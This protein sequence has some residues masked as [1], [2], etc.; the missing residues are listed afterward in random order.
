MG[1]RTPRSDRRSFG[2]NS[3]RHYGAL[4][5][6]EE[7]AAP[8]PIGQTRIRSSA[9]I[10]ELRAAHAAGASPQQ[11]QALLRQLETLATELGPDHK[12]DWSVRFEPQRRA[13]CL[14]W[15][16][17]PNEGSAAPE[18]WQILRFAGTNTARNPGVQPPG[19]G[20]G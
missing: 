13:L 9:K 11:I 3:S 20:F 10:E 5:P 19:R 2:G 7:P 15:R 17:C 16:C 18:P 14:R 4:E 12:L 1:W 8:E 6:I